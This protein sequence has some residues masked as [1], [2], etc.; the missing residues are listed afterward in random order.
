M[1]CDDAAIAAAEGSRLD[2]SC[3]VRPSTIVVGERLLGLLLLRKSLFVE[4]LRDNP[5][6]FC[7]GNSSGVGKAGRRSFAFAIRGSTSSLSLRFSSPIRT[8]SSRKER[9]SASRSLIMWMM[10]AMSSWVGAESW[11]S[12][13]AAATN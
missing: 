8:S 12:V 7:S 11:L 1:R 10:R 6:L 13:S 2:E 9:T 3:N 4:N 5:L